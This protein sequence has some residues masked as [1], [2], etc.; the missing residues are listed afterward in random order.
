MVFVSVALGGCSS[1]APDHLGIQQHALAPC[2]PSP[3][4]V[5]SQHPT[6]DDQAVPALKWPHDHHPNDALAQLVDDTGGTVQKTDDNYVWATYTSSIFRFVDDVEFHYTA[7][8]GV[9][10][11]RSAS[12][13]G[14]SDL[15]ANR[16]RVL[17][18]HEAWP[19]VSATQGDTR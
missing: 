4:C 16:R 10:H 18:M 14:Y 19:Q 17:E 5:A 1:T 6:S 7:D 8:D 15:G 3:N 13:I 12:R 9:I 2:P 11:I